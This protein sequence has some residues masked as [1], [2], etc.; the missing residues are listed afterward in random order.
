MEVEGIATIVV[1]EAFRI[2]RDLGPGLL[3]SVYEVVLAKALQKRGLR[4][5]R[6]K[7]VSFE[8]DGVRFDEGLRIDILV[9]GTLVIELKSV[10]TLA[11]VHFKQVLTY[12]RLMRLPLGLL[13]NFG[14]AT[15]K[16]GIN[17]IVNNHTAVSAS[18]L[19]VNHPPTTQP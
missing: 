8:F 7:P 4:V 16:Q 6:Q 17:R 14:A 13:I 15:A 9:D 5:E 2:H 10:E 1:D 18:P 19:R 3:E 12:L 11:P